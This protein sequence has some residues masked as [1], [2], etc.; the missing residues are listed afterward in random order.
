MPPGTHK[1][2]N[3]GKA[4]WR[5]KSY[6]PDWL[7]EALLY[8]F[9]ATGE[10]KLWVLTRVGPC[11]A[12]DVLGMCSTAHSTTT[13]LLPPFLCLHFSPYKA[14]ALHHK[15]FMDAFLCPFYI[16]NLTFSAFRP[17]LR[18]CCFK[19]RNEN[20]NSHTE[21]LQRHQVHEIP[22]FFSTDF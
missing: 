12:F 9:C 7:Q 10:S 8:S 13:A 18:K 14:S 6:P 11:R 2:R 5:N 17:C 3:R 16:H 22:G 20:H 4:L 1:L 21:Q 19:Y 15:E